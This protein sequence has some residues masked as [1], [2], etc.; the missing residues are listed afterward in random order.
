M[1]WNNGQSKPSFSVVRTNAGVDLHIACLPA[2]SGN[3][4][5]VH[6]DGDEG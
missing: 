4:H 5:P 6:M 3:Q 1:F 2:V